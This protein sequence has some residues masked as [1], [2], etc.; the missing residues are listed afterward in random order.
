MRLAALFLGVLFAL[1]VFAPLHAEAG[2]DGL[3]VELLQ[4]SKPDGTLMILLSGDAGWGDL[5]AAVAARANQAGVS[6]VGLDCHAYFYNGTTPARLAA[7]LQRLVAFY[8]KSW[9]AHRIILAGYSFGADALPFAW[10]HLPVETRRRTALIALVGLQPAANFQISLWEM[11]NLPA[12][13]DVPV[14]AA[15]PD[16]PMN[17]VLCIYGVRDFEACSLAMLDR[18][19]RVPIVGDH[20]LGGNYEL[21]ADAILSRLK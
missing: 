19:T 18:A 1:F 21:V 11:L 14:T 4:A 16:L 5:E 8:G 9:H 10:K 15:I 7:D 13:D 17:K 2:P 3:P 6:V 20:E 12:P